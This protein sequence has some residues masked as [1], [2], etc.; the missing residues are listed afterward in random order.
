MFD[1]ILIFVGGFRCSL[2]FGLTNNLLFYRIVI[3]IS[4]LYGMRFTLLLYVSGFS[5][6]M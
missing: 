6:V 1:F 2:A 4:I 5:F 3:L